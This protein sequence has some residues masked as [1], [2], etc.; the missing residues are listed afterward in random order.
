LL[1]APVSAVST[2]QA[3][4]PAVSQIVADDG[5]RDVDFNDG[6]LFKLATRTSTG[7]APTGNP[8]I[9][10]TAEMPTA[11]VVR[12]GYDT[13]DWR[14]LS[15]PHDWSVEG[16][17][18]ATGSQASHGFLQG[19]LGFYRKTFTVPESMRETG[20]KISIDFEACFQNCDVYLNGDLV[21]NYPSGYTG[22]AFD[23]TDLLNYGAQ[24][25]NELVV[26]AQ[27]RVPGS[28]WYN[29]SGL[30]RPVHLIVTDSARIARNGIYLTSP[31]L[32]ATYQGDRHGDLS[33]N[34]NVLSDRPDG[35]LWLS[36]TVL[37]ADGQPVGTSV[38][39]RAS[40]AQH[41]EVSL[42][43]SVRVDNVQLWYPWNLGDPY[44]YT[45]RTQLHYRPVGTT[46]DTVV[47]VQDTEFG[48]RWFE[49]RGADTTTSSE[50]GAYVNGLY[51]KFRG[52]NLHHDYSALGGAGNMDA[53]EWQWRLMMEA[54][55]NAYRTG[56]ATPD[57]GMV[58]VC[59]RLG[60]IVMDEAYD[61]WGRKIGQ[62]FGY[63]WEKTVPSDWSGFAT[64]TLNTVR[65]SID[66]PGAQLTWSEWVLQENV[67]RDFNSPSVMMWS[68]GN[69]V[70][71]PP[72]RTNWPWYDG[73]QYNPLGLATITTTT[74][75][76]RTEAARLK[77]AVNAVDT[78]RPVVMGENHQKGVYEYNATMAI[79]FQ[80]DQIL[81]GVGWNYQP[82]DGMDW[83]TEQVGRDTFF[84]ESESGSSYSSRGV[85]HNPTVMNTGTNQTPGKRGTSS[86]DNG[87][88]DQR[89]ETIIKKDRDRKSFLGQFIWTGIDYI[90]EPAP[91]SAFPVGVAGFGIIDTAG[92]SKDL[93]YAFQTQWVTAQEKPVTH[94]TP[95]D[96]SQ[97]R[98]GENVQVW[99]YSNSQTTELFLNGR[100]LGT[101][102]YDL[103]RTHDGRLFYETSEMT[104]DSRR[105]INDPGGNCNTGYLPNQASYSSPL[106]ATVVSASGDSPIPGGALCGKLHLTWDVPFEPGVLTAKTY[107]DA[108]KSTLISEDTVAT[109]GAAHTVK[110][111]PNKTVIK[112]DG[113]ALSFISVD[114]VDKAGTTLPQ[115]GNLIE[116]DVTGG[117][118][119]GV[120]NGAQD[121]EE[122]YKW[123][124]VERNTHSERSAYNGKALVIVQSDKDEVG[125]L[126]LTAKSDGLATAAV[127]VAVTEDGSGEAPPSSAPSTGTL[128]KVGPVAYAT[129]A[130]VAPTLPRGVRA[131]YSD[132]V[133]GSYELVVPVTWQM[134][135][136]TAFASGAQLEIAGSIQ[137]GGTATAY[138]SVLSAA[139]G[140]DIST[141]A[142]LGNNNRTWQ[143]E[144]VPADSPLRAGALATAS[145]SG[146]GFPNNVLNGN[147][148]QTWTNLWSKTNTRT[149]VNFS[150]SDPY[151]WLEFYWDSE[152]AMN[153][154]EMNFT[155]ATT[156]ASGTLPLGYPVRYTV[157]PASLDVTFWDGI[158]WVP[159]TGLSV[160]APASPS[161]PTVIS[162]D[163]VFTP[164]IRVGM[165]NA[166]PLSSS[167]FM[168]V[169]RA[170]V[171][172]W[173]VAGYA[174]D[175]SK[176]RLAQGDVAGL[177]PAS[178]T[179]S[180][181]AP[182]AAAYSA[183]DATLA[184]PGSTQADI[185]AAAAALAD[186]VAGLVPAADA[187]ELSPFVD[188]LTGLGY[189]G[190]G[191]GTAYTPTSWAAFSAALSA[192][193]GVLADGDATQEG[194]DSA[195]A[196]LRTAYT[197][198][199][200]AVNTAQLSAL[201]NSVS[202]IAS[203][204]YTPATWSAVAA[205]LADARSVLVNPARTQSQVD[206]AVGALHVALAGLVANPALRTAEL[207]LSAIVDVGQ[208]LA[209]SDGVYT[210]ASRQA[211]VAAIAAAQQLL[212]QGNATQAQSEAAAAA[213]RAALAGLVVRA[214]A[215]GLVSTVA[216]LDTLGLV[217]TDY[218]ADSWT[219]YSTALAEA[220]IVAANAGAT[221]AEVNG[222]LAALN[223]AFAELART[224]P[225]ALSDEIVS[226]GAQVATS[227]KTIY[228]QKGKTVNVPIVAYPAPGATGKAKVSW[229]ASKATVATVTKGKSSGTA[230]VAWTTGGNVKVRGLGVGTSKIT[231]VA[232]GGKALTLTVKVVNKRT[233]VSKVSVGSL[234]T[235]EVGDT[236][237]LK[238][239]VAPAKSATVVTWKSSAPSIVSVDAAGRV[240]AKA[241]GTAKVTATVGGKKATAT[242]S[243]Q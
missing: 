221:Q 37:T 164:K 67:R 220:R 181:W 90:G 226:T 65:P 229:E 107:T 95:M 83:V 217:A 236:A 50:G 215:T 73:T 137:G 105:T 76:F 227:M 111:A 44:L 113:K 191:A 22:F 182:V 232:P 225:G 26:R 149:L 16:P 6:W 28:R 241:S 58:Q 190:P 84:F 64:N 33:A 231:F 15:V 212:A 88:S 160:T 114:V 117:A 171:R 157:P 74:V 134:P 47:D 233:A 154:V 36:T 109:A 97:W 201:V 198:L 39:G 122:L 139:G 79:W 42:V 194:V 85:Y 156:N 228:V 145:F 103:K 87:G 75:D 93:F 124:N 243:V 169:S 34:V 161:D 23:L 173:E 239:K 166:T 18:V 68:L 43:N 179:A 202:A 110:L 163:P 208:G 222:A 126:T 69:E 46:L 70:S 55:V 216:G 223:V 66:Y 86:Y 192:A 1:V 142:T 147:N 31:D 45:V 193:Q 99:I 96:W 165:T 186:A 71:A 211:L 19:G 56:H 20:K 143:W 167:G 144:S 238:A 59:D 30:T 189:A 54:G 49:F 127:S 207:Q 213:L 60:I 7:P 8:V 61:G 224:G 151:D 104:N 98:E 51:T 176:L 80:V 146:S 10:D 82:D 138:V 214:D 102:S 132:P 187:A 11:D 14:T 92:F 140:R 3:E 57:R 197:G 108:T 121:S 2:A 178:W 94:I 141:N 35:E 52:V 180:T 177:T 175:W 41:T 206:A 25:T 210:P 118:I 53:F 183:A 5:T 148:A 205:K 237:V 196:A 72:A 125:T 115:A 150:A 106:G 21:G 230:S 153:Q 133:L 129:P 17:K 218:R 13:S 152:R 234:E 100:S 136:A 209:G 170:V 119:V 120:D 242:V 174:L 91:Y 101:K 168:T 123:G 78:T 195:L 184:D 9:T 130:G 38:S 40:A 199:A 27:N 158:G 4:G 235:M 77:A 185:D 63:W 135:S 204:A 131:T 12:P 159:V 62:D 203:S 240:T 32:R 29:G 24:Q 89:G 188:L 116:F 81:D 128:V 200:G 162:F 155:T 172:G 112:A 48:F 219:R